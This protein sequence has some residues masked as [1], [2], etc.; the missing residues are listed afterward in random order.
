MSSVHV[1]YASSTEESL[2]VLQHFHDKNKI[3]KK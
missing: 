3:R 2:G 1:S